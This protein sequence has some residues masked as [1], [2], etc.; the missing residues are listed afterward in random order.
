MRSIISKPITWGI[1]ASFA[2]ILFYLLI[3]IL[4]MPVN[5]IWFIYKKSWFFISGIVIGFGVQIG[6]WRYIK[7]LGS[8]NIHKTLPATSGAFSGTAMIA[9]CSHH[10]I[11]VLPILGLA[12]IS[13][14]LTQYQN[15]LLAIGFTI[16]LFGIAYMLYIIQKATTNNK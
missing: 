8:A 9:C 11:D 15:I 3:M 4:T 2:M 12:G 14:F 6:L 7:N 1:I 5:E 13:I 16:N 10:L